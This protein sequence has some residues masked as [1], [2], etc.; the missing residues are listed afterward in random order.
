M[1]TTLKNFRST[2]LGVVL[3]AVA[4]VVGYNSWPRES[5]AVQVVLPS[6]ENL[7]VGG[8]VW[9]NGFDSGWVQDIKVK[10][11]KA[12]VTAG[13]A[14]EN[15]PLHTG[16]TSRVQWYAAL[17]ERI[18]SIYPGPAT[19]PEIPNGALLEAKA[20]Q[21]E[22]DQVLAALDTPTRQKLNGLIQS[23]HTTTKGK[24]QNIQATLQSAGP[25]VQA[26][27]AIFDAVGRDGP[28]IHA[29]VTQLRQMI[30]VTARQQND[31][32]GTVD[33]LDRFSSNVAT[34]QSQ[35]SDTLK[36]L[37]PTLRVANDTLGDIP[38]AA[39]AAS[40]MLK[41]LRGA[42]KNLPAIAD[43]LEPVL[44][45]LR[46]TLHKLRPGL[47]ALGDFLQRSPE[48][49]DNTHQVLPQAQTFVEEYQPA[50]SFLRPYTPELQGW[51]QN[52]GKNF[53]S[54]DSQGHLWAA[55]LG[56]ASTQAFDDDPVAPP[57]IK[58]VGEPKPGATIDQPW[59]DA[60]QDASGG[61]V[62]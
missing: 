29:L 16:T 60:N 22:V 23:L 21:V 54:Y 55:N 61:P 25:T 52:W 7:A 30:E 57:P 13:I 32:R 43:D 33:G 5:Y 38:P 10:D 20:D 35:L 31:I 49:L 15:A 41:D 46:P 6:A 9:I 34:A 45:D 44:H 56:E 62:R 48:L 47:V 26:A 4:L 3:L 19:N 1:M 18:L 36:E 24:E 27:G 58:Q 59:D 40:K 37:P 14:R 8:K 28:A 42:T 39:D 53:G 50:I 12:V 17:G 11:G 2:I 51:L